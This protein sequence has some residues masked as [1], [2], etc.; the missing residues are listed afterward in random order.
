M[1]ADVFNILKLC[2]GEKYINTYNT[3]KQRA[4]DIPNLKKNTKYRKYLIISI[5]KHFRGLE[6]KYKYTNNTWESISL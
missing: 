4:L 3:G 5:L 2:R 6:K 1:L